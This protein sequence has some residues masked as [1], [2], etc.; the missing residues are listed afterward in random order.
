M[1]T[2]TNPKQGQGHGGGS[3]GH[4]GGGMGHQGAGQGGSQSHAAEASTMVGKAKDMASDA[5]SKVKD[6][7][8]D[9]YDK[10]KEGVSSMSDAA[11]RKM[12]DAT[13]SVGSGMQ[14]L[15]QKIKESG[16]HGGYLGSATRSVGD[17]LVE[18]GRYLEKEGLGGIAEDLGGVIKRNPVPAV[19]CAIGVGFLLGRSMRS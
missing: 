8:S 10:A 14:S 13:S 16:P 2:T 18:G 9:A 19:L 1:A 4:Q 12:D 5:A 7:A 15:G 11:G 6:M 17:S 3:Q